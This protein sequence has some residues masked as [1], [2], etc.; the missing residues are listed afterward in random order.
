MNPAILAWA[1]SGA[2]AVAVGF[3]RFA[4]ALIL[5]AMQADLGLN[6][7]QAGWLNTANALGYLV[8][9]LATI[10]LVRRYG[11][12]RLFSLGVVLTALAL[13]LTGLSRDFSLL[14]LYRFLAGLGAAGAF[15]C[16]GVLAG[17]IGTRAIVIFFSGS[18][19]GMLST[20]AL[21]PWLFEF[22]GPQAWTWAWMAIG[23]VCLPLSLLSIIASR[24]IE[25]PNAPGMD[26]SWEWRP[27]IPEFAGYFMFGLGYIAYITFIIAW[28]RQHPA[29][30]MSPA[31]VTSIM[32]SALGAMTLLAPVL[33]SRVFNGRGDGLPMAATMAVLGT[34]AA[35]P[36]LAPSLIGVW[37]SAALVGASVFMVPAAA[38]SFI[39]ANLPRSAWGS[40]LA[41]VTSLFAIG[42]TIGPVGAGWISDRWGNLSVGLGVSAGL[43]FAGAIIA[44]GQRPCPQGETGTGVPSKSAA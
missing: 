2:A 29:P 35:L 19:I 28:V 27:C 37:M 43:L 4:Y 31:A 24:R 34:G 40:G 30:G 21:L 7:A 14:T 36:M 15:I 9:A 25:E 8:G 38:T 11:N 23:V 44:M 12:R 16:G 26:A 20:G 41:V 18:G 32:W 17:V 1:L 3:A 33:W 10:G 22:S 42:Q 6:Y 39:K 5:P 13:I